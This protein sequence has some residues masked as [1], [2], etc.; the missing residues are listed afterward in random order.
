MI[1]VTVIAVNADVF[2]EQHL[3]HLEVS[4]GTLS[5]IFLVIL[6][7]LFINH[8]KLIREFFAGTVDLIY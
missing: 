5:L 2:M 3:P 8:L 4:R 6:I 1:I 7:F